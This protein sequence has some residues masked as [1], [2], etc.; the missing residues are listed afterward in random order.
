VSGRSLKRLIFGAGA[1]V[2]AAGAGA[3]LLLARDA[4][5]GVLLTLVPASTR[6]APAARGASRSFIAWAG[7]GADPVILTEDVWS[8]S[9]ASPSFD[10][11]RF[12]FKGRRASSEAP[13]IW[14]MRIGGSRPR[15][16]TEGRGDP[17][18]PAYLPDGRIVFSD[19][20]GE[21]GGAE[22][23]ARA[24]YSCALDGSDLRRLT[25]GV[26]R[27]VSPVVLE[28]GRVRFDRGL[29]G[30]DPAAQSVPMTIRPDG[31]GVARLHGPSY[32]E[33]SWRSEAARTPSTETRGAAAPPAVADYAVVSAVSVSAREVPPVLTSVVNPEKTTGTLLCLDAHASRLPE[34]AGL[35]RGAID[36]VRVARMVAPRGDGSPAEGEF[37]GEGPLQPDGS[38]FIEVPA[39]TPLSLTLVSKEGR[40]LARMASGIWVRPGENRGCIGCHEEGDRVP[41]NSRPLAVAQPPASLAGAVARLGGGD[42][43]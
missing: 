42:G 4:A 43:R 12:V 20:A 38:F 26:H 35:P 29:R 39:D 10:G 13:R 14:E 32:S 7:G 37:L 24:L 33:P 30:P 40:A 1:A 22:A 31:T 21:S 28:D 19:G 3:Y 15:A 41:E 18:D 25:F 8:A 34:I 16:I 27:D 6:E 17:D 9:S 2:V 5:G 36:R 11:R 23:G